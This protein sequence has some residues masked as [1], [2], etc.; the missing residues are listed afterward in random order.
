MPLDSQRNRRLLYEIADSQGGFFTA[1]QALKV[2]YAYSQQYFHR[3]SGAWV[4]VGRGLFRLRDYPIGEREDLV[5]WS[6]WSR[7][8][9]GIPQAVISHE[10]ALTVH[11]LSDVMPAAVHLTVPP[12]FRKRALV[13]CVL[14]RAE[15][16]PADSE[17][18]SGFRVTTPL[19]TLVD[20]AEST[21]SQEHLD[22]AAYDALQRGLVRRLS[23]ATAACS[24]AARTR[25]DR[26]LAALVE[27]MMP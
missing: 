25:L 26:A 24:P 27:E 18:R 15:L 3:Q 6:L 23:L 7:N 16:S 14:H 11:D 10:T 12:G 21:L 13:G 2:G 20:A 9:K 5:R 19:R 4:Q 1:N 22:R 8:Q 17:Q